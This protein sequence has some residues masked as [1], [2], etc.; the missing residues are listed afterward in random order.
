MKIVTPLAPLSSVPSGACRSN[1]GCEFAYVLENPRTVI[2]ELNLRTLTCNYV[3]S[4]VLGVLGYRVDQLISGAVKLAADLIPP[5]D[6]LYL[7]RKIGRLI[8]SG[9]TSAP[10]PQLEYRVQTAH[11]GLRW[12]A[13]S[14]CV[15]FGA[16]GRAEAIRGNISDITKQK[17]DAMKLREMSGQLQSVREQERRR[18][19]RELH[20]STAQNLCALSF[21]LT[22]L[23]KASSFGEAERTLIAELDHITREC[24]REIGTIS[25]LLHPPYLV[26][27]GLVEALRQFT[28]GFAARSG[29][30]LTLNLQP[31]LHRLPLRSEIALFRIVQEA[32]SNIHRHSKSPAASISLGHNQAG[33]RLEIA[34]SGFGMTHDAQFNP[35]VGICGMRERMAELCGGLEICTGP[36]GTSVVATLPLSA[37]RRELIRVEVEPEMDG[38]S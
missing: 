1:G 33:I 24:Q 25:Y 8:E 35:G 12:V 15:V 13:D 10:A 18:L 6:F 34:D 23:K 38:G 4:G 36:R 3:S 2:Y 31:L 27:L 26:E 17:E 19:G 37:S 14:P 22:L 29:V 20:D 7:R 5:E 11:R 28:T 9:A 21:S 30:E 32:L 16:D